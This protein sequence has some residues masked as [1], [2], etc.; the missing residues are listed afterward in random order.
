MEKGMDTKWE[1]RR[2]RR[3]RKENYMKGQR[4]VGDR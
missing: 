2:I 4:E 1:W 3:H